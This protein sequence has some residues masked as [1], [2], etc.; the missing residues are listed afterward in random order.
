[1]AWYL[2][3]SGAP[4][5][6]QARYPD[7]RSPQIVVMATSTHWRVGSPWPAATARATHATTTKPSGHTGST[8]D[9][10]RHA[11]LSNHVPSIS[12]TIAPALASSTEP[13]TTTA[14]SEELERLGAREARRDVGPVHDLPE[15]VDPVGLHVAVLQVV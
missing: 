6:R 7:R 10:S 14:C 15:R 11:R 8:I 2:G 3:S 5:L 4:C 13:V 1:M 9:A 12:T